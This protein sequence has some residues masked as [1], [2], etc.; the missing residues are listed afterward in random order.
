MKLGVQV[1]LA[2][3]RR[4]PGRTRRTAGVAAQI[5]PRRFA[6]R[7]LF[8]SFPTGGFLARIISLSTAWK[9]SFSGYAS[10]QTETGEKGPALFILPLDFPAPQLL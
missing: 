9:G 6:K 4:G 7:F 3:V 2:F 1:S 5:T 8:G 10:P